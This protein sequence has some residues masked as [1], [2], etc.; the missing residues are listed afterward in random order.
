VAKEAKEVKVVLVEEL[1]LV[2]AAQVAKEEVVVIMNLTEAMV[3]LVTLAPMVVANN[4]VV[5][6][7]V[8]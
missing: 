2:Q 3:I 4:R 8:L 1:T 7:M 6:Q 5:V